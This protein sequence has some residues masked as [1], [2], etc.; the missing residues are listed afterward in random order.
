MAEDAQVTFMT[1]PGIGRCIDRKFPGLNAL[2]DLVELETGLLVM[3]RILPSVLVETV[4]HLLKHRFTTLVADW[5]DAAQTEEP[6]GTVEK[7]ADARLLQRVEL[8]RERNMVDILD[9]LGHGQAQ[10]DD[11]RL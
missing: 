5:P 9:G 8:I 7:H 2:Q 10:E 3:I 6:E 11:R 4:H 1:D